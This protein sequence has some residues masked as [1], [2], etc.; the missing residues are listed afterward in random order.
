MFSRILSDTVIPVL[1]T[2]GPLK[3]C[4]YGLM[5]GIAFLIANYVFVKEF[6]RKGLGANFA[7]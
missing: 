5:V 7:N 1:F 6:H 2:I 3:V 4:S